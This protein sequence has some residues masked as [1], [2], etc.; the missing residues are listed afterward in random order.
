MIENLASVAGRV[1]DRITNPSMSRQE[2]VN[3]TKSTLHCIL[4]VAEKWAITP[5]EVLGI[6]V[7][8]EDDPNTEMVEPEE[9]KNDEERIFWD[10]INEMEPFTD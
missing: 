9:L 7:K 10:F 6:I 3:Y 1:F 5:D 2:R 8:F 4:F